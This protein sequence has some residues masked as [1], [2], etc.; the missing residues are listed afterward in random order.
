MLKDSRLSR[1]SI[2]VRKNQK[3]VIAT[4]PIIIVVLYLVEQDVGH[5]FPMDLA[6]KVI[7]REET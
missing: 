7:A 5:L 6:A 4:N 3:A 2:L 1:V